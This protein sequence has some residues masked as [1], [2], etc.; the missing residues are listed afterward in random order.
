MSNDTWYTADHP[1]EQSHY[2]TGDTSPH[3]NHRGILAILL[4]LVIFFS[5]VATA[6]NLLNIHLFQGFW[7][8][9]P[10]AASLRFSNILPAADTDSSA[11]GIQTQLKQQ[12]GQGYVSGKPWLGVSVQQ[13]S[14]FE[15][16][17]YRLPTGRYVTEVEPNTHAAAKGLVPGGILIS[18]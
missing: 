18:L 9:A 10:A 11:T 5:G 13:M 14:S 4:I 1:E 3:K 8:A 16:L 15:A 6:F 7:G 2:R 12:E 17:Y